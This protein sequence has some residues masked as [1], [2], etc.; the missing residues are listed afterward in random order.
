MPRITVGKENGQ[1]VVFSHG[2]PLSGGA[3][4]DQMFFLPQNAYRCV[5]CATEKD[6]V[7]EDLLAFI[8]S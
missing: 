4:E 6:K 3:F 7:N 5:A 1:S 2:R 8:K